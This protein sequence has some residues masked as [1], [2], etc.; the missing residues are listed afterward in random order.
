MRLVLL[1]PGSVICWLE[2][3]C[4]IC[5][6]RRRNLSSLLRSTSSALAPP[7][8]FAY[9]VADHRDEPVQAFLQYAV[10]GAAFYGFDRHFLTERTGRVSGCSIRSGMLQGSPI[11]LALITSWVDES[12]LG[13]SAAEDS[14]SLQRGTGRS[15]A[16]HL[17]GLSLSAIKPLREDGTSE[18]IARPKKESRQAWGC[19]LV[20]L[21]PYSPDLNP[22]EEAFSQI[23]GVLRR[24]AARTRRALV[25]AMC[26]ASDIR[27]W[28]SGR[29]KLLRA[30]RL[31]SAGSTSMMDAVGAA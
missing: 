3:M 9:G 13:R 15:E 16:A 18:R 7:L 26:T 28:C 10:R 20:Y 29:S 23:K 8:S 1:A 6:T 21:L 25:E 22:I 2:V 4:G 24:A 30:L 17:I 14:P 5:S 19:E 12:L 31:L 27:G 11:A